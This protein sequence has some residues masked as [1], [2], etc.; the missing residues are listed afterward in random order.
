MFVETQSI[1]V[2]LYFCGKSKDNELSLLYGIKIEKENLY[3]K[4]NPHRFAAVVG[5]Y[6]ILLGLPFLLI[7]VRIVSVAIGI[8]MVRLSKFCRP[9]SRDFFD[10][11]NAE[12]HEHCTRDLK[13]GKK[14]SI[15]SA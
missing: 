13:V 4:E 7:G 3:R 10:N 12:I 6:C 8:Y 15:A 5:I 9:P 1:F 2:D 11:H 14:A